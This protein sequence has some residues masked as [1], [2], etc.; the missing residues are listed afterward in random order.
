MPNSIFWNLIFHKTWICQRCEPPQTFSSRNRLFYHT[1]VDH[2]YSSGGNRRRNTRPQPRQRNNQ[3]SGPSRNIGRSRIASNTTPSPTSGQEIAQPVGELQDIVRPVGEPQV[4]QEI[5][6]LSSASLQAIGEMI[7][8]KLMTV[9]C[10]FTT[11]QK[12]GNLFV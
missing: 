8:Q 11:A 4:S 12:Q 5:G 3:N 1:R 7:D 6:Q 10:A 9:I 2:G